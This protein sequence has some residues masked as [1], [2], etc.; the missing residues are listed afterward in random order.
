MRESAL[1]L[2]ISASSTHTCSRK[3]PLT[4]TLH[5]QF[6]C[7]ENGS[8]PHHTRLHHTL[9][10]LQY[11]LTRLRHTPTRLRHT[12]AQHTTPPPHAHTRVPTSVSRR[13]LHREP[14]G[15][16]CEMLP[17]RP[18]SRGRKL[19]AAAPHGS[20]TSSHACRTPSPPALPHA[21]ASGTPSRSTQPPRRKHTLTRLQH[22]QH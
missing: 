6:A 18:V 2:M 20:G 21:A 17:V 19:L 15:S 9:T 22:T 4:S 3:P 12:L 13:R 1:N 11:T 10:R 5:S 7:L 16:L 14:V 8:L